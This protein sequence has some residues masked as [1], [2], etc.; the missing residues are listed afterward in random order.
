[1]D[2]TTSIRPKCGVCLDLDIKV[3]NAGRSYPFDVFN[4]AA[5]NGCCVCSVILEGIEKWT[6]ETGLAEILKGKIQKV[7]LRVG[8]SHFLHVQLDSDVGDGDKKILELEFYNHRG[9]LV[10]I[11]SSV[12]LNSHR[13][14]PALRPQ[15]LNQTLWF[16]I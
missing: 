13:L 5:S 6:E 14:F 8:G 9:R 7:A 3:L 16:Y 4:V 12:G 10:F 1:M 11:F 2:I 15:E